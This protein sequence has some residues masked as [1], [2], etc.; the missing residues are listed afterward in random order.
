MKRQELLRLY[1]RRARRYDFTANLYYLIGYREWAYRKMAVKALNLK[2]GDTV[3]EIGCG[4][5]L[6]FPLLVGA[7]G[8]EGK[9]IGVD[10]TEEMLEQA[11]RRVEAKGWSNVELVHEDAVSFRFPPGINGVISTFAITLIPEYDEVIRNGSLALAPQGRWVVL[12]LKAPSGWLSVLTPVLIPLVRPFG[13]TREVLTRRPW[14]SIGKYL[15]NLRMTELYMGL[16]YIVV[17]EA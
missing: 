14:E 9:V 2:H 4:T 8:P 1:R 7:V 10:M 3:V 6:N 15:K 13:A 5:G 16:S 11:G 17:G 12:D